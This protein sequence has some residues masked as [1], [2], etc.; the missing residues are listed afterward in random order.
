M[1]PLSIGF[2]SVYVRIWSL[3]EMVRPW[4][5][6]TI[7]SYNRKSCWPGQSSLL[8]YVCWAKRHRSN[9]CRFVINLEKS[10]PHLHLYFYIFLATCLLFS[11]L[12]CLYFPFILW[13]LCGLHQRYGNRR[14]NTRD[15]LL[16]QLDGRYPWRPFLFHMQACLISLNTKLFLA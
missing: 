14:N 5:F 12:G 4:K 3:E 13:E 11:L 2:L 1:D 7:G 9:I 6:R 16:C 8:L 15:R 10:V